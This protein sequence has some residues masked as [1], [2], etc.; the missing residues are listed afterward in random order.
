[1]WWMEDRNN[2]WFGRKNGPRCHNMFTWHTW[3][4]EQY[5]LLGRAKDEK[6]KTGSPVNFDFPKADVSIAVYQNG[7]VLLQNVFVRQ[8]TFFDALLRPLYA[9]GED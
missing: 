6:K 4:V 8:Q 5:V 9:A 1:M 2:R 7:N 3:F